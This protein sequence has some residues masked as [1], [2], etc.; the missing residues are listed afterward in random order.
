MPKERRRLCSL[1]PAHVAD[2][3]SKMYIKDATYPPPGHSTYDRGI[4]VLVFSGKAELLPS[5]KHLGDFIRL[6]QVEVSLP[7]NLCD[8]PKS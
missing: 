5:L 3:M 8:G 6:N 4:E 2:L 7:F 1:S